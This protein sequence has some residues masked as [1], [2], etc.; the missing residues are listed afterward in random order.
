MSADPAV[1]AVPA[2]TAPPPPALGTVGWMDLTVAD[3]PGVRDFYAAVAGWTA[4]EV[5]MGDYADYVM[6][7]PDGTAVGGV[8][9]ARGPNAAIPPHWLMYITVA[10]VDAAAARCT[11]LGG[12]VLVGPKGGSGGRYCVF[13]DPAGAVAALY[14]NG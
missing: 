14:Q 11:E 13:Q 9:H 12:R 2:P 4:A 1:P 10:D 3:A 6:Q 8:C 7:A 5:A